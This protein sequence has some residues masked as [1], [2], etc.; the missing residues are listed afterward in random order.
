MYRDLSLRAMMS[1][2]KRVSSCRW[3]ELQALQLAIEH[4]GKNAATST[5]HCH[6]GLPSAPRRRQRSVREARPVTEPSSNK[7]RSR[8]VWGSDVCATSKSCNTGTC[9]GVCSQ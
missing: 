6:E 7:G 9:C 4:E 8:R 1:M 5:N 2:L 3:I